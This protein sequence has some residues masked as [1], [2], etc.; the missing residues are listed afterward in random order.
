M[1]AQLEIRV[2]GRL[3]VMKESQ[4]NGND[5]AQDDGA[6]EKPPQRWNAH[7]KDIHATGCEEESS[8]SS[9]DPDVAHVDFRIP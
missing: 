7:E 9:A 4:S 1:P 2:M 6:D 3:V 5:G 8:G